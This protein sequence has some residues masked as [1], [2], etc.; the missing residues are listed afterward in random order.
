MTQS[1]DTPLHTTDQ[2]VDRL[3]AVGLPVLL[4]FSAGPPTHEMKRELERIA[5]QQAGRLL[6]AQAE[7]RDTA[8]AARRFGVH[9]PPAV[10]DIVN[11]AAVAR[12][13]DVSPG[14]LEAHARF[15]VGEGPKPERK[16][17]EQTGASAHGAGAPAFGDGPIHVTDL[18]FDQA[19]LRAGRPVLVD[20]WA[21]WCGPCRMTNP[22]VERLAR[23][24]AGRLIVAKVN[25]DENP[26]SAQRYG[27]QSIP[28]MMVVKHG[29]IVDRWSGAMPE[30]ALRGRIA[31]FLS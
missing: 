3:L 26:I 11:G 9:R 23:E 29:S 5:R 15:A 6:V 20:F 21:P 10:V 31:A 24:E 14:E 17:P 22:V 25:V 1:F 27:I 7:I 19:V 30:Q 8:D 28:T 16:A 12:E 2:A 13:N 18:T 4:V